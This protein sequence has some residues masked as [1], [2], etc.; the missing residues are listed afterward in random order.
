[1]FGSASLGAGLRAGLGA[2]E[3]SDRALKQIAEAREAAIQAE[4]DRAERVAQIARARDLAG[5]ADEAVEQTDAT[6]QPD[7]GPFARSVLEAASRSTPST[8]EAPA[9]DAE[10]T[11][12][13]GVLD[14]TV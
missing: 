2:L 11:G 10:A 1:M 3:N 13:G 9:P 4:R 8:N 12:R 5:L 7:R 6:E 14:L